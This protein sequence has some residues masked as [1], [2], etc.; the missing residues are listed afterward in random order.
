M[1]ERPPHA[2]KKRIGKQL[3]YANGKNRAAHIGL[4][5]DFG[6]TCYMLDTY[7]NEHF[8]FTDDNDQ[9]MQ[10][11]DKLA[12]TVHDYEQLQERYDK[13]RYSFDSLRLL[14]DKTLDIAHEMQAAG[15]FPRAERKRI[16]NILSSIKMRFDAIKKRDDD[17]GD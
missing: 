1:V 2:T 12:A 11:S 14:E 8:Y 3:I 17:A 5:D 10:L 9:L 7:N 6:V 15:D 4:V 16:S 13:L